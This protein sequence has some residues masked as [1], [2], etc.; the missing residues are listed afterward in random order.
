[1]KLREAR[2]LLDEL[3]ADFPGSANADDG[4]DL[5]VSLQLLL[6]ENRPLS[7]K[8]I[9]VTSAGT[10]RMIAAGELS[11]EIL[12]AFQ[13][14]ARR[15]LPRYGRNIAAFRRQLATHGETAVWQGLDERGASDAT[16]D[17]F[18]DALGSTEVDTAAP[19][20]VTLTRV[21]E[22]RGRTARRT[23]SGSNDDPDELPRSRSL[24]RQAARRG[25]GAVP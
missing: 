17:A 18:F 12:P 22:T 20:G 14:V 4:Y 6:V 24:G 2:F 8:E 1:M 25:V 9:A 11:K 3:F 21:R 16:W 23:A 7:R 10:R 5:W 15:E 19:V 13:M